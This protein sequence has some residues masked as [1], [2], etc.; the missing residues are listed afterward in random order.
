MLPKVIIHNS[1]S[2]DGSLVH[3][4][5]NMPLHYRLAGRFK[6]DMHLVGSDTVKA[7]MI[8]FM[9]RIPAEA[10]ADFEKPDKEGILWA[11]P[12]T[13]GKLKGRLHVLRR[14]EYCKD[15]VILVS[16]KTPSAYI[17]YLQER[18]FDTIRVGKDKCD[19]KRALEMLKEN[20]GAKTILTDSGSVLG[21]ALLDQ[22]LVSK[23]S[24][25]VHPVIVGRNSY[26]M[27]GHLT[28]HPRLRLITQTLFEK[29]FLWLVY[30]VKR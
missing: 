12:D 9:K 10:A 21:N 5:V 24:L 18:N 16:Q 2:L 17:R 23:I 22:G 28:S 4:E 8:L 15:V 20:Y 11:I 27:F 13:T 1:V 25:L 3:F 6:A 19:L 14:T 26:N 7:G 29:R 30:E